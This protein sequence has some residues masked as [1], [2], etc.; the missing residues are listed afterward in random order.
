MRRGGALRWLMLGSLTLWVGCSSPSLEA[1]STLR[2]S[3][4]A[5]HIVQKP[6]LFTKERVDLTKAYI[7]QHYGKRVENIE[8]VPRVI[9]IHWTAEGS[10]EKSYQRFF[11]EHLL[12]DRKDIASASPLNV[13]AHF[14]V[15]RDGTIYQLMPENQMARHVIG[16]NFNAIGIENVGGV[17]SH[18]DLTPE[19]LRAN[20]A[21]VRYLKG[22]YE[23]I[24]YLIGHYEY[25]QMEK[26]PLWLERDSHYRT[27][28]DD[29]APRFMKVLREGVKDL[30]L[31]VAP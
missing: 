11:P 1:T 9:V 7:A 15:D 6:I 3:S 27:K 24:T 25:R 29:P 12:S 23:S 18:D 14:L 13:S 19:Q 26:T 4:T 16:L 30:G 21:L 28:K 20:R 17:K 31:R 5:L 10:F 2:D 22:R 8:I